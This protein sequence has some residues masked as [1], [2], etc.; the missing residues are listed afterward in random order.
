[1][2]RDWSPNI[3][4]GKTYDTET[5]I[6]AEVYAQIQER[7]HRYRL[8][9][10]GKTVEEERYGAEYLTRP[11]LGQGAFRILVTDAYQ[12]RCAVT[13]ERTLPALEAAHIKPYGESGPHRVD[14]GLLLRADLH[15]LLDKGYITLTQALRVEVSRKIKE[16]FEN[17]RDY[18]AFHGKGLEVLPP[19][20]VERPSR[21]FIDWHNHHRYLG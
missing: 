21:E 6:G 17:G 16:D 12:R 7:L 5:R 15:R 4:S 19:R 8:P 18:Y 3:V 20:A 11:R 10:D 13:G 14:N 2:P 9:F 1:M